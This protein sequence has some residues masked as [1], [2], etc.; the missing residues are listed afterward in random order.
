LRHEQVTLSVLAR[1]WNPD[2]RP[3]SL[4]EVSLVALSMDKRPEGRLHRRLPGQKKEA[5][6]TEVNHAFSL[7]FK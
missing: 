1:R 3:W 7:T 6:L 2:F 5:W 4:L